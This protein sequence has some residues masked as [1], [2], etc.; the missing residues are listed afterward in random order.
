MED[1]IKDLSD[2]TAEDIH[3]ECAIVLKNPRPPK[4][5]LT[6]DEVVVLKNII[7]RKHILILKE[8]KGN[9]ED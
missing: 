2:D 3:Q 5:N 8:E 4:R 1:T 7:K 6:R 9:H